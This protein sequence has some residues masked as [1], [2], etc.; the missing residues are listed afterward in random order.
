M[1]DAPRWLPRSFGN[2]TPRVPV[3]LEVSIPTVYKIVRWIVRSV[4]SLYRSSL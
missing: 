1:P 4:R 3:T 2:V